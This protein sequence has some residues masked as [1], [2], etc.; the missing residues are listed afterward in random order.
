MFKSLKKW[1]TVVFVLK[2]Y[3]GQDGAGDKSYGNPVNKLC[4]PVRKTELVV[5]VEG[6]QL[7]STTQLYIDSTEQITESDEILFES[8]KYRP[9]QAISKYY[10]KGVF[11]L[12]VVYI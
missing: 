9:V 11:S 5:S 3:T 7:V 2:S 1:L 4:Y 10:D 8:T 12:W 6:K